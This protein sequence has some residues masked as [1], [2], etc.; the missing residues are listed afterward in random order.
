MTSPKPT[1]AALCRKYKITPG[2]LKAW[3]A[4]GIDIYSDE[5]MTH[6]TARKHKASGEE[7]FQARLKKLQAEARSATLKAA[8]LEGTLIDLAEAKAA[9]TRI[10]AVTKCLLLRMQADLPPALEGQTASRMSAIIGQAV[11]AILTQLSDPEGVPWR[12]K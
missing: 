2:T 3:E 5:A 11:E 6:R 9:T 12:E 4:E 1:R 8:Q 7:M 10:G